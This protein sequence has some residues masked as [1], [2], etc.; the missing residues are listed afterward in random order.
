VRSPRNVRIIV[1]DA[2]NPHL[3]TGVADAVLI[4]NTYHEFRNPELMLDHTLRALRPGGRLV[5]VDR[6]PRA[7]KTK[8]QEN[9]SHGHYELPLADVEDIVRR[10][11][12]EIIRREDRFIDRPLDDPWWLLAA[13][14]R[15]LRKRATVVFGFRDPDAA[16]GLALLTTPGAFHLTDAVPGDINISGAIC[17]YR[18]SAV[19]PKGVAH[20]VALGLKTYADRVI[21][22]RIEYGHSRSSRI[23]IESAL[24]FGLN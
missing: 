18:T 6:G 20:Q 9:G 3:P 24:W 16:P 1:G 10:M 14:K 22:S 11:G 15:F 12:F 7:L 4:A 2:D 19:Q 5:I 8:S 21:Q 13:R 23:R 17:C